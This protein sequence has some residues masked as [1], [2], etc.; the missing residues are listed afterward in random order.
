MAFT[1]NQ[2]GCTVIQ[3]TCP[4]KIELAGT[5]V[6]GDS[7]GYSS[8]WKRALATAGTA[9]GHVCV[10]G[11]PGVSGDTITVYFGPCVLAGT[12]FEGATAGALLYQ[13]EGSANG[14]YTETAPTTSSDLATVIGS[15]LEEGTT[16]DT[17]MI[18]PNLVQVVV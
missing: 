2:S 9:I 4:A 7:I 12:R 13:A 1:D 6:V 11:E 10:A 17:I 15:V 8:G 3:G 5:V 18:T 16:Y 14:E